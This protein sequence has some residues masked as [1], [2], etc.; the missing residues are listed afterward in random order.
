MIVYRKE[1]SGIRGEF[2]PEYNHDLISYACNSKIALP[3][4]YHGAIFERSMLRNDWRKMQLHYHWAPD[5]RAWGLAQEAL[6]H[7]FSPFMMA[8]PLTYEEAVDR[9]DKS[10]SAGYPWN[11]K[12]SSKKIA[13]EKEGDLIKDIVMQVMK[14]GKCKFTFCGREFTHLYWLASPKGEMRVMEKLINPDPSKR[15]C[16]T[17]MCSDICAHIMMTMLFANQNDGLLACNSSTWSKVGFSPFY[18]GFDRMAQYLLQNKSKLF[19]LLF[20]CWD[21]SHMEASLNEFVLFVIY[22]L[23]GDHLVLTIE[24]RNLMNYVMRH[25]IY[26]MCIDVD[27]WLCM[28]VGKNPS[29]SFNTLSDNTLALILVLFYVLAKKSVD[30]SDLLFKIDGHFCACV[31]DDSVVPHHQDF[32]NIVGDAL[33]LGFVFKP[34][35]PPGELSDCVFTNCDFAQIGGR[36]FP[37]PNFDKVKANVFFHFKAK[38]WRLSYIKCCALRILSWNFPKEREEAERLCAYIL[39]KYQR[40]MEVEHSMDSKVTYTSAISAYLPSDQVDFLWSGNECFRVPLQIDW[41]DD[42]LY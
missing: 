23:R 42:L 6:K 18:G 9:M 36:W 41:L 13:L 17:F 16:R 26:S 29:G 39:K 8:S 10:A 4:S 40:A 7:V 12:Y 3:R 34:E 31:G 37:K 32:S 38:S 20:D 33:D 27:G 22:K 30:L 15:K 19:K 25:V 21:V 1:T 14:T 2:K 28:M 35:R 24:T 11:L 5:E